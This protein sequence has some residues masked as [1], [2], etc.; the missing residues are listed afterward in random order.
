MQQNYLLKKGILLGVSAPRIRG[1]LRSLLY[2]LL[3]DKEKFWIVK[4]RME[5][6]RG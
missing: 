1:S 2:L 6:D 5:I 3:E 4:V